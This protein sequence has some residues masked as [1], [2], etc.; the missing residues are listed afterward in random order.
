[1]YSTAQKNLTGNAFANGYRMDQNGYENANGTS[2]EWV[3][4]GYRTEMEWIWNSNRSQKW[5]KVF[6]RKQTIRECVPH[7]VC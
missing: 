5:K 1:M 6:S 2:T 4:N 7:N 3:L